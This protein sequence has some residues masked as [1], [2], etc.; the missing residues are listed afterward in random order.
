MSDGCL[1]S[2]LRRYM[3]LTPTECAVLADMEREEEQKEAGK[4][5]IRRGDSSENVHV[6]KSGWAV[7]RSVGPEGRL[8]ILRIF[9]PGDIVGLAEVGPP[10]SPHEV[11]MQTSGVLCSFPRAGLSRLFIETPRL[12]ALFFALG[13]LDQVALRDRVASLGLHSAEDR[14]IHFLLDLRARL[15]I[16]NAQLEDSFRLP[17]SQAEIGQIVSLTPVYVN[18]LLRR[19][20]REGRVEIDKPFIRL[21]DRS[22]MERQIGFT[23][24]Y[25]TADTSWFPPPA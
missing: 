5:V 18:R 20:A 10:E 14:I 1:V 25:Y 16:T 3:A 15:A 22:G 4:I 8:Q 2:R 17:F 6:L 23:D 21:L 12:A 9:L 11:V 13:S 7:S 19:M 24:R